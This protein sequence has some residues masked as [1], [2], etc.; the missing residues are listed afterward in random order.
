[1][2]SFL[3]CANLNTLNAQVKPLTD[4]EKEQLETYTSLEKALVNT[5][6]VQALFLNYTK[7]NLVPEEIKK[8]KNIIVLGLEIR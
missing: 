5:D 4:L 3:M 8:F 7:L 1:M 2:L 6:S